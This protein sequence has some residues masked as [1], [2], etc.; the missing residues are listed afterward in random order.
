MTR[1][2]TG[3][4]AIGRRIAEARMQRRLTNSELAERMNAVAEE[5][6]LDEHFDGKWV[7]RRERGL[8]G[9]N[10][11]ELTV[12]ARALEVFSDW[13][14]GLIPTPLPTMDA[15]PPGYRQRYEEFL[16]FIAWTERRERESQ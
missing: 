9:I 14:L 12:L 6:G 15:L 2:P 3:D 8:Y 13:L 16:D 11:N 7:E 10:A 1:R 5:L 4:V